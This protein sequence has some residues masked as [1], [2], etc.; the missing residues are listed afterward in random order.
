MRV[1]VGIYNSEGGVNDSAILE[2]RD[3]QFVVVEA[4]RPGLWKRGDIVT[5]HDGAILLTSLAA[6]EQGLYFWGDPDMVVKW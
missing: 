2:T 5:M 4:N 3:D 1:F 6:Y